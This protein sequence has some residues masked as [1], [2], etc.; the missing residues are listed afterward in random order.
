MTPRRYGGS[1]PCRLL[2][3]VCRSRAGRHRGRC[4]AIPSG[5]SRTRAGSDIGTEVGCV[6]CVFSRGNRGS[7]LRVRW[8]SRGQVASRT[9]EF[10]C[11]G[12]FAGSIKG[13]TEAGSERFAGRAVALFIG[14]HSCGGNGGSQRGR[15]TKLI[16]H[17][18]IAGSDDYQQAWWPEPMK[19]YLPGRSDAA[20]RIR[21]GR[22]GGFGRSRSKKGEVED[23]SVVRLLSACCPT[24]RKTSLPQEGLARTGRVALHFTRQ[25]RLLHSVKM[26]KMLK[27]LKME[28]TGSR[29]NSGGNSRDIYIHLAFD[30]LGVHSNK[31]RTSAEILSGSC[32]N[33]SGYL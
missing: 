23:W 4:C 21:R 12:C 18:D 17:H 10:G 3:I 2:H 28:D 20:R 7:R 19:D 11:E 15:T 8:S 31:R 16:A 14:S 9:G 29:F 1:R 25:Q 27:M 22:I 5:V 24:G 26:L 30:F 13:G 6:G 32:E 33:R